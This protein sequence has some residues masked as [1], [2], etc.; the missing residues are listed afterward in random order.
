MPNTVL[1][2][3]TATI[4][5]ATAAIFPSLGPY[6]Y[7]NIPDTLLPAF[8]DPRT[9]WQSVPHVLALRDGTMRTLPLND[10]RGLVS[11]PSFHTVLA[12][13]T[14]WAPPA[15]SVRCRASLRHQCLL[16]FRR[17]SNG[18]H[19]LCDLIGGAAVAFLGLGI[20]TGGLV[21]RLALAPAPVPA[22]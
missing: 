19:Y 21:P 16:I 10:L 6:A 3:L 15:H 11:F 2:A 9:G 18:D 20:V 5:I 22:E 14:V 8:A 1:F 12:L 17:P 13:V 7:F 4:V